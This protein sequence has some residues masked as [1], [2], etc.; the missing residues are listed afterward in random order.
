ML[1]VLTYHRVAELKD[2][3]ALNPFLSSAAPETF[4][5]QMR[6]LAEYY[7]VIAM[8]DVLRA[9]ETGTRL[10]S[11]SVL[12]TFDDAY[13]DFGEIA[14]PILK[15]YRL[16]ATLF[17]PTAYPGQPHLSFWWDRLYRAVDCT[18]LRELRD[19]P[20]G[21]LRLD[22]AAR[23]HRSLRKMQDYVKRFP[24]G[25]AMAIVDEICARLGEKSTNQESVLNWDQ[26]RQLAKEGVT[27]GAHTRTHPIMTQLTPVQIREEIV[28]SQQD[29]KREVGNVLPIFSYPSGSHDDVVVS[30]LKKEGFVLA[31]TT[32]DGQNDL[33]SADLLRLR[34]TNI[35][36]RTSLPIFRL[37]LLRWVAY[38]D[39]WRHRNER[40]VGQHSPVKGTL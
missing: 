20:L 21:A 24:H 26:L 22:T 3:L 18:S 17:V 13:Q 40:S 19:T 25:E 29:L 5:R 7:H 10:S 15:R 37:R 27:L 34:R 12:L 33:S 9:V 16:P 31:F 11:R 35:S 32:L 8:K 36:R 6:Y 2:G 38:L 23:R 4:A 28:G 30:I 14:W 39:M 1:R